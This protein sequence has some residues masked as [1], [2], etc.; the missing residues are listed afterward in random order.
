MSLKKIQSSLKKI[1]AAA[2]DG[3]ALLNELTEGDF[4][5]SPVAD[6]PIAHLPLI[7][8]ALKKAE[9]HMIENARFEG[10]TPEEIAQIKAT[11][12]EE[13]IARNQAAAAAYINSLKRQ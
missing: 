6:D 13:A 4:A 3:V 12:I 2:A 5:E 10:K 8:G 1:E 7:V 11:E 9:A